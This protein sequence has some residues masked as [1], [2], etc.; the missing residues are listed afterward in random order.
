MLPDHACR[1]VAQKRNSSSVMLAPFRAAPLHG[2]LRRGGDTSSGHL[3]RLAR[4]AAPA[5]A[6]RLLIV[7]IGM[8]AVVAPKG[9]EDSFTL[10]A[11]AAAATSSGTP[12]TAAATAVATAAALAAGA[13]M[14]RKALSPGV[15]SRCT[16]RHSSGPHKGGE[17]KGR[18]GALSCTL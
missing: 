14:K 7:G 5:A 1:S 15:P 9:L 4:P 3:I 17:H 6:L 8:T 12:G 16:S 2:H 18:N 13:W 10:M 11:S